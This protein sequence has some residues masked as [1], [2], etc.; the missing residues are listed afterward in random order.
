VKAEL[1]FPLELV[2]LIADRVIEKLKPII[3]SNSKHEDDTVFDVP[4]LCEY[5]KIEPKWVYEQTHLKTIPHFKLG[6]KQL[7][8]K[9]AEIDAWIK[10]HW[11]PGIGEPTCKGRVATSVYR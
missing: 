3:S 9:K 10:K 4:G 2:D 6:N 1:T 8:F 5:L 11:T 7:R